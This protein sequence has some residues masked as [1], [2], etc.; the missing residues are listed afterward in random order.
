M[1]IIEKGKFDI[2]QNRFYRDGTLIFT[3]SNPDPT[4]TG[5]SIYIDPTDVGPV[6]NVVYQADVSDG[7]ETVLSNRIE[8]KFVYPFYIGNLTNS[9]PTEAQV[10][11]L[12]KFVTPKKNQQFIHNFSQERYVIAYPQAYGELDH[13]Y[14]TNRFETIDD[15]TLLTDTYT[16][17]DGASVPYFIYVFNFLTD[18]VDFTNYFEF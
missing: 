10:K 5:N 1:Q 7:Q 14:D 15:Y 11:T 13:I 9:N 17:L 16:M 4:G 12:Q 2:T 3:N 18:A 6:N 8:F